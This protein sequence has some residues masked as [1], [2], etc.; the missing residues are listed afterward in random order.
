MVPHFLDETMENPWA[1]AEGYLFIVKTQLDQNNRPSAIFNTNFFSKF[2]FGNMASLFYSFTYLFL[3]F[4]SLI[5]VSFF[6]FFF[7]F[8]LSFSF[9]F[10]ELLLHLS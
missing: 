6:G 3:L 10:L 2:F 8:I 9:V 1:M 7:F 4:L 5:Q